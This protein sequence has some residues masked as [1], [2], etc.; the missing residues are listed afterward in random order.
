[1]ETPFLVFHS[2]SLIWSCSVSVCSPCPSWFLFPCHLLSFL[3][4]FLCLPHLN[5]LLPTS[6]SWLPFLLSSCSFQHVSF[7]C[8]TK[9]P[10]TRDGKAGDNSS[11]WR[12]VQ[13]IPSDQRQQEHWRWG[14]RGWTKSL[15]ILHWWRLAFHSTFLQYSVS[16]CLSVSVTERQLTWRPQTWCLL[17]L[18]LLKD[19]HVST[20]RAV[21]SAYWVG[22]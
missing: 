21:P 6:P 8:S 17:G 20:S 19:P 7:L 11:W 10:L 15:R 12:A 1:M 22:L 3:F 9:A 13:E 4:F 18:L 5:E 14:V 2:L 16:I